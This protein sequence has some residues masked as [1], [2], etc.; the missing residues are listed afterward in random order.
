MSNLDRHIN[1]PDTGVTASDLFIYQAN[2]P[3]TG[4]IVINVIP[5]QLPPRET[6]FLDTTDLR[7]L[8][9]MDRAQNTA[10]IT[11]IKKSDPEARDSR[12]FHLSPEFQTESHVALTVLFADGKIVA[13]I[14]GEPCTSV[15]D[16]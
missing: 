6:T 1:S 7:V 11:L 13:V 8:F 5:A 9:L 15:L 14:D 16:P 4:G 2:K 12:A 10:E 3:Y